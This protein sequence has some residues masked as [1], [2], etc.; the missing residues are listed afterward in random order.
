MKWS[1]YVDGMQFDPSDDNQQLGG[2]ESAGLLLCRSLA[3][4]GHD[5]NLFGK[6]TRE[7]VFSGVRYHN[8][9]RYAQWVTNVV[10]DVAV[11]QRTPE[12]L[13]LE[14]QAEIAMI[15]FHDLALRRYFEPIRNRMWNAQRVL[16]LSQFMR[17]QYKR[18]YDFPDSI[19]HVT[20]NGIDLCKIKEAEDPKREQKLLVYTARPERGMEILLEQ[21]FPRLLKADPDLRLALAGYN[22]YVP[23]LQPLYAKCQNL[24][25]RFGGRVRHYGA[26]NKDDLYKLYKTAW[27]YIYPSNFEEISC[28]TAMECMAAGLPMVGGRVGALPE[29]LPQTCGKLIPWSEEKPAL[30]EE[31]QENFVE[32][33][34]YFLRN[35][36]AWKRASEAGKA[37]AEHLDWDGV[38]KEWDTNV[39]SLL[40]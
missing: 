9:A 25:N 10:H 23:E 39:Q 13:M 28:I 36:L 8:V 22:A 26:L 1:F 32:A 16:V 2:S 15:W 35:E 34:L 7:G 31:Y 14:M 4:R 6:H 30:H 5:V 11:I 37:H 21:T 27:L 18:V 19:L 12:P 38:A 29:T 20:R 40:S 17:D 33:C 24:V 3:A